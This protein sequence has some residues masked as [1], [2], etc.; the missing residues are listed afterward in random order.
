LK[1]KNKENA[2][3]KESEM[4]IASIRKGDFLIT[5]KEL[6]EG[7]FRR[8]CG[9]VVLIDEERGLVGLKTENGEIRAV[10]PKK[11]ERLS[12][13]LQ[14][15]ESNSSKPKDEKNCLWKNFSFSLLQKLDP[16]EG[17]EKEILETLESCGTK[18]VR[19]QEVL[20]EMLKR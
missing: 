19:P 13:F 2:L 12:I 17:T 15:I 9:Y 14:R 16:K 1:I 11:L 18:Q 10:E 4:N 3:R 7:T 8:T 5:Q 20:M 6:I